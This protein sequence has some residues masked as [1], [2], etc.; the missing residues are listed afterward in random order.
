MLKELTFQEV[1]E[2]A[3]TGE[4]PQL[5]T[6][7][8]CRKNESDYVS[9]K[10][11]TIFSAIIKDNTIACVMGFEYGYSK[12]SGE[13]VYIGPL[14]VREAY[15]GLGIGSLAVLAFQSM[16]IKQQKKLLLYAHIDIQAF[17]EKHGFKAVYEVETDYQA[18]EWVPDG[19]EEK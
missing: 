4:W 16:A 14:C 19:W 2:L 18:M 17:Y 12:R 11:K 13:V 6:A 9:G 1:E 5:V 10:R 7:V 3:N 8:S 15:R